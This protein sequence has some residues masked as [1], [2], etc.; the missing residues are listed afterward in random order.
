MILVEFNELSPALLDRF[1]GEG[2]LPN[3]RALY[4]ASVIFTTDA[5]E[6]PP[7]LE[8]WIQ[9]PTVHSGLSY[10]EHGVFN[11]GDGRK[12]LTVKLVGE[13]LSDAGIP[14]GICSSMNLNYRD[15]NGYVIPDSWDLEGR[16]YPASLQPFYR[17]V[18]QA[19]Q[20][21]SKGG[22]PSAKDLLS[23]GAF[24]LRH[25]VRPMTVRS[26]LA[27]LTTERRSPGLRWR[28]A[29]LLDD[30]QYDVFRSLNRRFGVRFATF[31]SN[32]TAHYQHYHWRNM[33]PELFDVPPPKE[34]D[35]SFADAIR[36]GYRS[37][38]R[39]IGRLLADEPDATL[40]LCT[41]LS[42]QPWLET[43]KCIF[44][45][46]DFKSLLNFAGVD[47]TE[48]A[49]K[50]VMAQQFH[51]ELPSAEM[52]SRARV[53]LLDMVVDGQPLMSVDQNG[54]SLF[55]GCELTD[56]ST[57]TR[58]VERRSD[59][60]RIPFNELFHM[61]HTMRSGWHHRDGA[62]WFRTGQHRRLDGQ[63]PLTDIAPTI[64]HH[65]GVP[66]PAH[67]KGRPLPIAAQ[68]AQR[69]SQ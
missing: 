24:L 42:Q 54:A 5:G 55:A 2:L 62:L 11:L 59:G 34:D 10:G 57:L 9:W 16:T 27:Q 25:G 52:A 1:M 36:Y 68:A 17:T 28:R 40:V 19:V 64:L 65:F 39:L 69:P 60:A 15:L 44:R 53:A 14:V 31:F 22:R 18:A 43:T 29:S 30:L 6:D 3:F 21:S 33:E 61:I 67:M 35:P 45:P 51:L 48:E 66:Q 56:Y 32:S 20:E 26:V 38:D 13:V 23:F 41:A 47:A 46:R 12:Q 50:P 7:N 63:V 49:V 8:P 37:M 4:E 58:D